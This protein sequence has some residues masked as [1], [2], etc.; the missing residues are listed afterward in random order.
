MRWLRKNWINLILVMIL[1][2]G[3]GL[4]LYPSV[5]DYWNSFHQSR[6]IASYA[7]AVANINDDEYTRILDEAK[8]YNRKLAEDGINWTPK[9]E[10][11]REYEKVLDITGTGIMGYIEIERIKCYL[12]IY[13]GVDETVLQRA[14]GHIAGTSLP[15]G[16]DTSHSVLSGHRGLPSAKLFSELDKVEKGD[17]FIIRCLD[18]MMTYEV[19]QILIV[20]PHELESIRMEADMDYVTLVTCTPYGVNSHRLLVR[21]HRVEN[22]KN[23]ANVRVTADANQLDTILVAPIMAIPVLLLLALFV[24]VRPIFRRKK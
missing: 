10:E 15:V 8:A 17:R 18:E 24:F 14:I 23:V 21:G 2:L 9:L 5:A 4:L 6:A 7:E 19:D 16:G 1:L 11:M 20:L 12:P 13:H 3:V 22:D